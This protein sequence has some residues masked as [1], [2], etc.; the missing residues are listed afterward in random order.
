M[1]LPPV[2]LW[3]RD[4]LRLADHAPLRAAVASGTP[5]IPLFIFDETTPGHWRAGA[6]CHWW[7]QHQMTRSP[8]IYVEPSCSTMR[9][10]VRGKSVFVA[11]SSA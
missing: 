6:A 1:S 2:I 7:L 8:G 5:V 10:F 4:D 11:L 9:R 3:Y